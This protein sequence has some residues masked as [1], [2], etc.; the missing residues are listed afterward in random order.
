[1]GRQ[2]QW[3]TFTKRTLQNWNDEIEGPPVQE[4]C[5]AYV[6]S[7]I[8]GSAYTFEGEHWYGTFLG[9]R[10]GSCADEA[11][12]RANVESQWAAI[13]APTLLAGLD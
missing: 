6:G 2:I 3:V 8:V 4:G 13:E 5:F 1:M 9:D 7:S 10:I 12:A 11:M